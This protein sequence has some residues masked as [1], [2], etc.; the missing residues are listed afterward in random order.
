[1]DEN[2]WLYKYEDLNPHPQ[3]P[4]K[5]SGDIAHVCNSSAEQRVGMD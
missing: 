3:H 5:K 2:I 4:S 1:M